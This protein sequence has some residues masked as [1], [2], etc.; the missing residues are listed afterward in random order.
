VE[1]GG[2]LKVGTEGKITTVL[3][4][5]FPFGLQRQK[6]YGRPKRDLL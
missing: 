4:Q 2:K 5:I 3:E 6:R 1:L